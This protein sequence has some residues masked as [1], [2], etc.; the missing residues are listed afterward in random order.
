MDPLTMMLIASAAGTA[1]DV[2]TRRMNQPKQLPTMNKDQNRIMSQ[3]S[4]GWGQ[5]GPPPALGQ[6]ELY[7]QGQSLL[8]QLLSGGPDEQLE[9]PLMR[10]YREQIIPQLVAQYGGQSSSGLNNSLAQASQGLMEQLGAMR[11]QN[12]NSALGMVQQYAQAP[13]QQFF[14]EGSSML[15]QQP[16]NYQQ[17][18]P[19]FGQ[20]F[21]SNMAGGFSNMMGQQL[22]QKWGQQQEGQNSN[23]WNQAHDQQWANAGGYNGAARPGDSIVSKYLQSLGQGGVVSG[24]TGPSANPLL[25]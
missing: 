23:A 19:G 25:R 9:A 20:A 11:S 3:M 2:G 5:G 21:A 18:G 6:N 16:F 24:K 4:K 10:Q 8:Q 7:Q 1:L 14:D 22:G 15:Q 12:R 13:R 17:Q